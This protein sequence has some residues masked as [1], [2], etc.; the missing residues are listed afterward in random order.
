MSGEGA[1]SK[2]GQGATVTHSAVVRPGEAD[3]AGA[4]VAAATDRLA[5][6]SL[7]IGLLLLAAVT[8][9]DGILAV[10]AKADA[11]LILVGVLILTLA[12]AGARFTQAAGDLLRPRGRVLLLAILLAILGLLHPALRTDYA[13]VEF[14]L[15]CVAAIVASP[16]WVAAFVGASVLGMAGDYLAA[17]HTFGW[18]LQGP[19]VDQ[20]V[21]QCS[22]VSAG[23]AVW[24]G[25][26]WVLR[27]TIASAPTS[28]SSVRSGA[29]TSLTPRYTPT[30]LPS[31]SHSP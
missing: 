7:R 23:A 22:I 4:D 28:L 6:T 31:S 8:A 29:E 26:I 5:L 3:L 16:V 2:P 1:H 27:H 10:A 19:G 15:A 18:T 30:V 20:L 24:V 25:V 9:G 13:D 17:G 12:L 14:G 21:S 11:T